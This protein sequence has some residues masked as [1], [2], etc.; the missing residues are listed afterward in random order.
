MVQQFSIEDFGAKGD[1]VFDNTEAFANA[2]EAISEGGILIIGAG[3]YLTGP[4][5][6]K[7]HNVVISFDKSAIIRFIS[8]ERRY[9]PIFSRWEGVNCYCMHPCLLVSDSSNVVLKGPAVI[10]GNGFEWWEKAKLKRLAQKEPNTNIE[11]Q[12]AALNPNYRNQGG[13]GGGRLSQFLR[14]P[15][16]QILRSNN[17]KVQS[18]RFI[19]SPFWTIH[20][21]Y[22]S[23]L[24][25]E[26]LSIKNPSDAPNTDG[27][28]VDS[29]ENVVINDCN[30]DVGDDGIVIKSGSGE[31]GLKTAK[32]TKNI[33]IENCYVKN[34]HGGT[35]IGSETAAGINN[36]VVK[37]CFFDGT[38]RGIRIKT[39]RDRGGTISFLHFSNVRMRNVICPLTVNMYYECDSRDD[40]NFD[41]S[42]RPITTTTPSISDVTVEDCICED[43]TSIAAFIVGLPESP[44]KKMKIKNC[45]FTIVKTGL[46]PIKECEMYQ[47]LPEILNRGIRLRNVDIQV[48]NV[49]VTGVDQPFTIESGVY[50]RGDNENWKKNIGT[51]E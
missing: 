22:S 39:R 44:I 11:K 17:I 28:D 30:L 4:I 10:D 33:L 18:L 38:D 19:N 27:I 32:P 50:L 6:I 24:L 1:G 36:I 7:A 2:F 47:G 51:D 29:C 34:A 40:T 9:K 3:I 31:D 21:V 25:F 23:E 8:D 26:N 13:G 42:I 35:S 37:N 46:R 15:L 48:Q 43:S 16:F 45:E 41:L 12:F 49:S 5:E 20:P 14:P